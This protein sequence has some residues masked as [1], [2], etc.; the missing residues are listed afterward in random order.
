MA[1]V[2]L[3]F[4]KVLQSPVY[5]CIILQ[6]E[7]KQFPIF[8]EPSSG[9]IL[10]QLLLNIP[11]KRPLPYELLSSL[12]VGF[13]FHFHQVVITE[14]KDNIFFTRIVLEHQSEKMTNF[15]EIDAR[16]SDAIILA[17]AHKVPIYC[18]KEVLE[19]VIPFEE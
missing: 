16:P 19:K 8:C 17:L 10:Q 15:V 4:E 9:K 12:S 6:G 7:E 13:E 1:L 5:T 3:N 18:T 14:M 2:S 11:T